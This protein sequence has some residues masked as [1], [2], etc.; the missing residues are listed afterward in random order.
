MH[1]VHQLLME[2]FE[3]GATR[4]TQRSNK[5]VTL[6]LIITITSY[7]EDI[8]IYIGDYSPSVCVCVFTTVL[9]RMH[10]VTHIHVCDAFAAICVNVCVCTMCLSKSSK[11]NTGKLYPSLHRNVQDTRY[12]IHSVKS[13]SCQEV[14]I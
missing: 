7:K 12:F 3:Y 6:F 8:Y 2:T 14:H 5:M 1:H 10:H 9:F 11:T 4:S 13:F